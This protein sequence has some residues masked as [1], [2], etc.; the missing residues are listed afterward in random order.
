MSF[1]NSKMIPIYIFIW[2]R[3]HLLA[4]DNARNFWQ[5]SGSLPYMHSSC[6]DLLSTHSL[7]E[8]MKLINQ[9]LVSKEQTLASAC[10][11]F[12]CHSVCPLH[13]FSLD[14]SLFTTHAGPLQKPTDTGST[15]QSSALFDQTHLLLRS[16]VK[17]K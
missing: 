14:I 16:E 17:V 12:N 2:L 1:Q 5:Q 10:H 8:E 3:F 7:Q 15:A 11:L 9:R 13:A 6:T 4:Q